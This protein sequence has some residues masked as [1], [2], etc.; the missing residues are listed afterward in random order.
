MTQVLTELVLLLVCLAASFLYSGAEIGF[1]S[2]SRVRVELEAG[3]GRRAVRRVSRLLRDEPALLI[4]LLI[5]NN[6]A[7]E[8]ATLQGDR[9]FEGAGFEPWQH[10]LIV[11]AVLTPV[12]F[13]LGEALPKD[14]FRRRPHAMVYPSSL[15]VWVSRWAFWPLERLLRGVSA[16]VAR[17]LGL[18]GGDLPSLGERERLAGF[19]SEGRRLGALHERAEALAL[20]ALKL[21]TIPISQ[22]MV[23][24]VDVQVLRRGEGNAA[25]FESVRE[26]KRTRLPVVDEKGRFE[27]YVHQL[28]VL[29][30]G[31]EG[32]VLGRLR[33]LPVM[34]ADTPVDRALS[35][36][37]AGGRRAAVVGT[38]EAP[39]GLVTLKDLV[40]EISGDLVGL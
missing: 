33:A 17:L 7:L 40:E 22:A 36:L 19:L 37:R 31:P 3:E 20:N 5:G 18:R 16:G 13:L 11:T 10:A 35:Q 6:I 8:L 25:L 9:L 28:E 4:T 1:Y 26:S 27:G 39:L 2:L 38:A 21:R 34:S 29:A 32:E 15:V 23:P 30:A 24:W 14:L 12:F